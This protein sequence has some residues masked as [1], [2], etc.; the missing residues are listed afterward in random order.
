MPE[1]TEKRTSLGGDRRQ[2]LL[3]FFS[4]KST[5]T[6]GYVLIVIFFVFLVLTPTIYVLSKM[7]TGWSDIQTQVLSN[8]DRMGIVWNA[9]ALSFG[10]A[11]IVTI[12]DLLFGLPLAWFLV[13]RKF[14]GKAILNTLIDSPLA[15][16]TAGLG[17]SVVLF[18]AVVPNLAGQPPGAWSIFGGIS[19]PFW[20]LVFL[21][22]TTTFPYM[23]RSLSAI[24]DEIDIEYETAARTCGAS[25]LTA[26]RTI[27]LPLFRSGLATGSILCLAKAL[28]ETG[29]VMAALAILSGQSLTEGSVLNGTALIGVW[30]GLS[31]GEPGL[32]PALTFVSALLIVFSLLLLAAVKFL[33]L[34]FKIP[35]RKVWPS[36][37][38][39]LSKGIAPKVRD[40]TAFAFLIIAILIPSFFIAAFM[41]TSS[42]IPATPQ[43]T[44]TM[45]VTASDGTIAHSYN[46]SLGVDESQSNYFTIE[47]N[48]PY[49]Y[50]PPGIIVNYT[51]NITA[52]PSFSGDV[53]LSVENLPS[54]V[55][56]LINPQI[57]TPP[58]SSVVTLSTTTLI[59]EGYYSITVRGTNG[60]IQS[61]LQIILLITNQPDFILTISPPQSYVAV[62][63]STSYTATVTAVN[64]YSNPVTLTISNT[65]AGVMTSFDTEVLT[66]NGTATLTVRTT[67]GVNWGLFWHGIGL[68]LMIAAI[69]TIADLLLGIPLAI[70][71]VRGRFKKLNAILDVL[72][73][74]PYVVPSAALGI[75]LGLFFRD[76]G[77]RGF[78]LFLVIMAH[79]VF[80]FPFIVRNVIGGLEGL[81]PGYE[82]TARTLGARPFQA[83]KRI[84]FPMI[85]PSIL[86]GAIMGFTRSVGE[87]GATLAVSLD[88]KTAPILIVNY[89][90]PASRD[91][92]TAGLL[93]AILTIVTAFAILLMRLLTAR[94][95]K[96]A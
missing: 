37:E 71:I 33:T 91:L 63:D 41:A 81:D 47:G 74:V 5:R 86:A 51:V 45:M 23:V 67:S 21:H 18:W 90:N 10:V 27:T 69:A 11:F 48:P 9:I 53:E 65:P 80:T 13:R 72:V 77:I 26:A 3:D 19:S 36:F 1:P 88:V 22:L 61:E 44:H 76:M 12:L 25:K 87:T 7:F 30:K 70:L 46:L 79:I 39:K 89:T 38:R 60:S 20:I 49:G 68:S 35:F 94:R 55:S 75:S 84:I 95:S 92:Y 4:K 62:G 78:D 8:S 52:M 31:A 34:K 66:P 93:I 28:S 6:I 24:L 82:D 14:R 56:S 64:N 57:V 32:L 85:K 29:G 16:P 50:G 96:G 42:P 83:F 15:V 58:A 43:G 2:P 17:I 54:E 73:N 59:P 40:T